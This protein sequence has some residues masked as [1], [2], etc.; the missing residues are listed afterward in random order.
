M[1][2]RGRTSTI[3]VLREVGE[4]GS[5][6]AGGERAFP[7]LT[8]TTPDRQGRGSRRLWSQIKSSS[9]SG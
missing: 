5:H 8:G 2:S 4:R 6:T 9:G 7:L 3:P 1:W